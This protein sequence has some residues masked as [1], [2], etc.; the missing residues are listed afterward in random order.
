MTM[1]TNLTVNELRT[2]I[3]TLSFIVFTG[4][5]WWAWSG[6]QKAR[7]EEASQLPFADDDLPAPRDGDRP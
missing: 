3:T 5:V 4:I 1:D 7:F 2:V 6:R